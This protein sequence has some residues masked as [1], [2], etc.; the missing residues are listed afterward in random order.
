MRLPAAL[1]FQLIICL[2]LVAGLAACSGCASRSDRAQAAANLDAGLAAGVEAAAA[3]GANDAAAIVTGARKYVA[4]AADVPHT[5]WPAP[6]M[7]PAAIRAEPAKYAGAA[8][9]EP[10]GWGWGLIASVGGGALV[11]ARVLAP[12]LGAG[13]LVNGIA[14][15]AWSILA[16]RDQRAADHA[17]G[18]IAEAAQIAAPILTALRASNALPDH[19]A[20]HMNDPRITI[21]LDRLRSPPTT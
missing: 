11:V 3:A 21:A 13:P 4:P 1:V 5:E 9:P 16:T 8:P 6:T 18:Q 7:P 10:S 2:A 12:L 15:A 19:L 20:A 17:T 14:N